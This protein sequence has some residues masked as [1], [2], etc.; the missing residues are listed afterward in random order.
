MLGLATSFAAAQAQLNSMRDELLKAVNDRHAQLTR[1][2]EEE[3]QVC[4]FSQTSLRNETA[5]A[6]S[7]FV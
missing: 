4:F 5:G 2:L 6:L 7:N 3:I 1:E